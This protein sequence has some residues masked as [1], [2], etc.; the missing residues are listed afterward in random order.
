MSNNQ[1]VI[2]YDY[3]KKQIWGNFKIIENI[4]K[5]KKILTYLKS[6]SF[7]IHEI[8]VFKKNIENS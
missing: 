1:L 7:T 6:K 5:D 8:N 2:N 4:N 3:L